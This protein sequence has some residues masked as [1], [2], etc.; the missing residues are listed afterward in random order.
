M[1]I[2]V[3]T[4]HREGLGK[5]AAMLRRLSHV[6]TALVIGPNWIGDAVMSTPLLA[7]LRRGLA[8]ARLD[9]LVTPRIAPLFEDHPHVDRVLIWHPQRAWRDR[10][11]QGLALRRLAYDLA[12]L[13]PNSFRAALWGWLIG[14]RVRMGYATDGRGWLLSQPIPATG[15]QPLHQVEAYLRLVEALG[16]PVIERS[17]LLVPPPRAEAAADQVWTAHGLRPEERVVG[18]CPGAAFGPAKRWR[19]EGFA[20]L[21]DRLIA[22]LGVRVLLFGSPDEVPLVEQVRSLMTQEA[23]SLAGRDTLSTFP[24]LAARCRVFVT[25]DSASMHIACAVGTP[26]VAIFGPTD[27]RRTAP[28][29]QRAIVLRHVLPCSP[30]F[31]TICPYPD[32]PC[33]RLL[34]VD[35]VWEAVLRI[36]RIGH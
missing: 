15:A 19:P 35:E 3:R 18:I 34:A 6:E 24:A 7:N 10:L 23:I 1:R 5:V 11:G 20:E 30:C 32:H 4:R 31:R 17:P 25:N 36:L 27:P 21:A 8:K 2:E 29:A 28:A 16:I 22:Q 33:M 9:L 26:V 13:L 12:V 14:A